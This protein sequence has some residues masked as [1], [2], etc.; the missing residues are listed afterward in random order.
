MTVNPTFL[1]LK[2]AQNPLS[3]FPK[4]DPTAWVPNPDYPNISITA[5]SQNPYGGSLLEDATRLRNANNTGLSGFG[6]GSIPSQPQKTSGQ[7]FG[8][9]FNLGLTDA[10]TAAR[11][12]LGTA[13]LLNADGQFVAPTGDGLLKSVAG[14]KD[15]QVPGVLDVD[16]GRRTSG[17]YPLT[18]VTYAAASTGLP[19]ADRK[20]FATMIRYAAGPGQQQG[21][22]NGLLPPGYA[23]LPA[24][25][26]DQALTA[27]TRLEAGVAPTPSPDGAA[28]GGS[29]GAGAGGTSGGDLSGGS[30]AGGSGAAGGSS[31]GAAGG[32]SGGKPSPSP[33][34]AAAAGGSSGGTPGGGKNAAASTGTTP[35]MLLGAV[36]W[37]LLTVLVAGVAASLAGPVLLRA[38]TLRASG[39]PFLPFGSGRKSG[40]LSVP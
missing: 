18:T 12:R 4:P 9:Y 28:G 26:R 1:A 8:Q 6:V 25:L 15:G 24:K 33:T 2:P 13:E 31:G 39:K 35:G 11:Y 20:D 40:D 23:P 21:I 34:P 7:R 3:E 16:P 36:R 14:M 19:A 17:A 38:G 30:P 22:G 32:G 37:V 5:V 29:G 10:A 27:A